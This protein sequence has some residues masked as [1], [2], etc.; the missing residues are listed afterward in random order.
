M[1]STS[2][3]PISF[4]WCT[5]LT[6]Q[7]HEIAERDEDFAGPHIWYS[8]QVPEAQSS[9][10]SPESDRTVKTCIGIGPILGPGGKEMGPQMASQESPS[11][12]RDC[13]MLELGS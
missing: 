2:G 5:S 9:A 1:S 13:L 12:S 11:T 7:A 10:S 4:H 6:S 3:H 8:K